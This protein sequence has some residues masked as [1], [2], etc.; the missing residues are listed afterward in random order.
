MGGSHPEQCSFTISNLTVDT[1]ENETRVSWLGLFMTVYSL[2]YINNAHFLKKGETKF[3]QR[4]M[5][6]SR[7]FSHTWQSTVYDRPLYLISKLSIQSLKYKCF[8]CGENQNSAYTFQNSGYTL[9]WGLICICEIIQN[10]LFHH[11]RCHQGKPSHLLS[12][13]LIYFLLK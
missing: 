13:M 11:K 2:T 1:T 3:L 5:F 10:Q 4:Y 8:N 9:P 12:L 7:N 6:C